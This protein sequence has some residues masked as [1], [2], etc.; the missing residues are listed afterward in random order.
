MG[1]D[2]VGSGWVESRGVEL[3]GAEWSQFK[4]S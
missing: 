2:R 4:S 3:S 1:S